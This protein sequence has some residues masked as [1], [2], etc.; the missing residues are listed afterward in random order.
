LAAGTTALAVDA[1]RAQNIKVATMATTVILLV[2]NSSLLNDDKNGYCVIE[3]FF[4]IS[5][6][7]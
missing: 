3:V 4:L 5:R 1:N 7:S 2:F 6:L